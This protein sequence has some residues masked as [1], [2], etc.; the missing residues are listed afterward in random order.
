MKEFEQPYSH[1]F[2]GASEMAKLTAHEE[3]AEIR[4]VSPSE[5]SPDHMP[6][7]KFEL[8]KDGEVIGGAEIDYFSKPLP[9][10]QLTDLWVDE[11]HSGKGQ[12]S[13]IMDEVEGFLR[14]KPG[15]LVDA[16]LEG[17][18]AQGMYERRGWQ[19]DPTS[20]NRKLYNWPEDVSKDVLNGL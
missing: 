11:S 17:E 16:I 4:Y 20:M 8:V 3:P 1:N 12:A 15:V 5:Q 7:H 18:P 10:Y 19:S 6:Q 14:E 13:R 9:L 2:D